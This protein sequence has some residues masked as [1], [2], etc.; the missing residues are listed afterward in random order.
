MD[1]APD[2]TRWS[3][4][5]RPCRAADT[6]E[7][8]AA[9]WRE[10][11]NGLCDTYRAVM[12]AHVRRALTRMGGAVRLDEAEDIVEGFL[13]A[14]G[15]SEDVL[16]TDPRIPGLRDFLRLGLRRY[17]AKHVAA[18]PFPGRPTQAPA[19]SL[20]QVLECLEPEE[21]RTD[22]AAFSEDWTRRLLEGALAD[23]RRDSAASADLLQLMIGTPHRSVDE[24]ADRLD[25]PRRDVPM[26][27]HQ[28]R[29]RLTEA[30]WACVKDTVA[31]E[32]EF[33]RERALLAPHLARW[34]R[35]AE[36]PS[37]WDE[38]APH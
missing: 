33:R 25:I 35:R 18:R 14:C 20:S 37:P 19:A 6:S 23:V 12:E 38:D 17:A 5:R 28:A 22:S 3:V 32:G 10:A 34:L 1:A 13:A 2:R 26:R 30:F 31:S 4:V 29:K 36:A 9:A 11:W 7:P 27:G 24:V 21:E 16:R 15:R 8:E